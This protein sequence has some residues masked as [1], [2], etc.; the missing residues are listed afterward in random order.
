MGVYLAWDDDGVLRSCRAQ[1]LVWFVDCISHDSRA[2]VISL[3]YIPWLQKSYAISLFWKISGE[4][5]VSFTLLTSLA[6]DMHSH[7]TLSCSQQTFK[8]IYDSLR[9]LKRRL[10]MSA[11]VSAFIFEWATDKKKMVGCV[12]V[13]E[14]QFIGSLLWKQSPVISV[15]IEGY[16]CVGMSGTHLKPRLRMQHSVGDM[17]L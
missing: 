1:K 17:G 4:D 13:A 11:S 2:H 6:P 8:G 15:G 9:F 10:A 5:T 3:L 14:A 12:T 16:D 7:Y